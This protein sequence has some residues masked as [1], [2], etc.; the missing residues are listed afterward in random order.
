MSFQPVG[1][2]VKTVASPPLVGTM[3]TP[4]MEGAVLSMVTGED[5]SGVP[6]AVPSVGVAVQVMDWPAS[7]DVPVM[8]CV[9]TEA[10]PLT[11]QAQV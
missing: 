5:V 7:K 10:A 9:V 6:D 4:V 1:A 8:V 2:Q 11:V 3:D